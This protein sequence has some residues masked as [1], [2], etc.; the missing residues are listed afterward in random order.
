MEFT[1]RFLE[2]L[3]AILKSL[4][5]GHRPDLLQS[6]YLLVFVAMAYAFSFTMRL[7]EDRRK[8][9]KEKENT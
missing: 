5:V 9:N 1:V 2:A 6:F 8:D 7:S 4:T 3:F